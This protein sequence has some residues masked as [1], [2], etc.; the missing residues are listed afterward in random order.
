[1]FVASY[2]AE[3]VRGLIK[4][5]GGTAR[6]AAVTQAITALGGTVESFDYAFGP[7]DA[8]V[9]VELPDGITA[10]AAGLAVGASGTVSVRTIVLLTPED[11][12]AAVAKQ[13]TFTP[14]GG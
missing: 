3:G 12:E 2:N 13:A 9:L 5:G 6:R 4:G 14:P 10:A 8:Y 11:V 7:D 1:M